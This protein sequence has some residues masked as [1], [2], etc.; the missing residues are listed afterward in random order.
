VLTPVHD[1]LC[2]I[3]QAS[4]CLLYALCAGDRKSI[5]ADRFEILLVVQPYSGIWP[6]ACT[7]LEKRSRRWIVHSGPWR[8]A[9]FPMMSTGGLPNRRQSWVAKQE[10]SVRYGNNI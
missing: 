2:E 8:R 6:N 4:A 7:V 5:I 10:L 3:W 9:I 1:R